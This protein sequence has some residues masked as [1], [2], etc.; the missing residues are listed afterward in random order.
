MGEGT[1]AVEELEPLVVVHVL[2]PSNLFLFFFE[3]VEVVFPGGV[4]LV[5]HVFV[6]RCRIWRG[7]RVIGCIGPPVIMAVIVVAVR[8]RCV[9][10]VVG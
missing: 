7:V 2:G 1:G 8:R 5:C 6:L 3:V 9:R 10:G 4:W